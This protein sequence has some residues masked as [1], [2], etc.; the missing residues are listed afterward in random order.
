M[1]FWGMLNIY[2]FLWITM[3]FNGFCSMKLNFTSISCKW[4]RAGELG[5][6]SHKNPFMLW[7]CLWLSF[8]DMY[9]VLLQKI[10]TGSSNCHF[11]LVICY[12]CNLKYKLF[13]QT[14]AQRCP[15]PPHHMLRSEIYFSCQQ[16]MLPGREKHSYRNLPMF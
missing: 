1:A 11:G 2:K 16:V 3:H 9:L 6:K 5:E 13:C 4:K 7:L 14:C 10:T 15:S 12:L 8:G